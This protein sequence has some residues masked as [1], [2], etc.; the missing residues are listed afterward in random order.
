V[1]KID[2]LLTLILDGGWHDKE[3]IAT[4]ME[5]EHHQFRSIIRL[6]SEFG[7]IQTK[8]REIRIDPDTKKLLASFSRDSKKRQK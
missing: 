7:L 8:D 2:S 5:I 1:S 4:A 3:A 6:L